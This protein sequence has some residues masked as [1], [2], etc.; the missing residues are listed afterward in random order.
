MSAFSKLVTEPDGL[1]FQLFQHFE[2]LELTSNGS[3]AIEREQLQGLSKLDKVSVNY[4]HLQCSLKRFWVTR[5]HEP[6]EGS[7]GVWVPVIMI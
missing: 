1:S 3:I 2:S 6:K 5:S 7:T 4:E